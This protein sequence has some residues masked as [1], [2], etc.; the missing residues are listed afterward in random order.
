MIIP[1]ILVVESLSTHIPTSILHY[2]EVRQIDQ[3]ERFTVG[4]QK[5]NQVKILWKGT[6][7]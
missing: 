1:N 3:I 4:N 7:L 5:L 6:K 2:I